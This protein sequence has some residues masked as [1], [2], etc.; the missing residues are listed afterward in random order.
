M[1][2]YALFV[3]MALFVS[4]LF[5]RLTTH[6]Q[7]LNSVKNTSIKYRKQKALNMANSGVEVALNEITVDQNAAGHSGTLTFH[8]GQFDYL[9]ERREQDETLS[10]RQVRITSIGE[11]SG[12]RDTVVVHIS[13]AAFSRYAY[14]TNHEGNIW[15]YTGD[16]L[17]GPVHTNTYFQMSG[18]P[19]FF[20][21]VTSHEVYN[22]WSPYRTYHWG[23]T[24]P[25]FHDGF[26]ALVPYI[27]M[28]DEIP[29]ELVDAANDEG[30]SVSNRYVWLTFQ[31]DGTVEMQSSSNYHHPGF[32]QSISISSTNGVFY[33][34]NHS[35]R[36]VCF[37]EGTVDG[38]V[39]VASSGDIHI[40]SDLV[41]YDNPAYNPSSNDMIGLVAAKNIVVT[42]NQYYQDRTIH[43]TIMTMNEAISN[44]KNF[45]VED[46]NKYPYGTLHLFGGLIQQ[47]RGAVGTFNYYQG[48]YTGYV[49]NYH[50]DERLS[51][52]SPPYF[53][54]TTEL[55]ML[56]WWE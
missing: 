18:F 12:S 45:W 6:K 29:Q 40:T 8:D 44:H 11:Y 2:R 38:Q 24:D 53:P 3:V 42:D 47:S 4:V 31:D 10:S 52:M 34:H 33:I 22:S 13:H 36:P 16:T 7:L 41:C 49:K 46:Y 54:I 20:G 9:I 25:V 27:P 51:E 48:T 1:G 5:I 55:E 43:A 19:V 35:T 32:V 50:W 17:R 23:T 15:F 14:F 39:T 28:P 30:V 56:A 26:E 37:V 21:R